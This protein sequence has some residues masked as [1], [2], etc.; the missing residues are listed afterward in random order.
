MDRCRVK[1]Y[2]PGAAGCHRSPGLAWIRAR[3]AQPVLPDPRG[4][5]TLILRSP[6][7]ALLEGSL[8]SLSSPGL[9]AWR[10]ALRLHLA[11]ARRAE[12]KRSEA[13]PPFRG[14]ERGEGARRT[15]HQRYGGGHACCCARAGWWE[16]GLVSRRGW[17]QAHLRAPLVPS[18]AVYVPYWIAHSLFVLL[19][20]E[21][22]ATSAFK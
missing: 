4:Q 8:P 12:S 10:A 22:G 15:H 19:S 18:Q 2:A 14:T 9:P 20:S 3:Q 13:G 16:A 17:V 21:S 11:T 1:V 6:G 7:A 5:S